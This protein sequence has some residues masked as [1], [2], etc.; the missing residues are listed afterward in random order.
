MGILLKYF[1][2][3]SAFGKVKCSKL[4]NVR[5]E[6]IVI[7]IIQDGAHARRVIARAGASAVAFDE[8]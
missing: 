6:R 7:L 3:I 8:R 4:S 5:S 1:V 2:V